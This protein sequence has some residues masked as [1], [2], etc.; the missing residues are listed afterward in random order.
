MNNRLP[1]LHL[2]A[3]DFIPATA[4]EKESLVIMRDS[5][6]FWR[7]G[8]RRLKKNRVAMVSLFFILLIMIFAYV[9]PSFWP[10]TYDQQIRT[11]ENLSPFTYGE[12][13]LARIEA[14]EPS[15]RTAG[16]I[17]SDSATWRTTRRSRWTT[18]RN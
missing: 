12:A 11:S 6:N 4:E 9:L 8:L 16:A 3:E 13:E 17:S 14:G 2:K 18:P 1:G 5:V 7:D 15:R 10:Y